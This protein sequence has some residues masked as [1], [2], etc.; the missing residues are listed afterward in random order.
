MVAAKAQK[1]GCR[2][3]GGKNYIRKVQDNQVGLRLNG[4][5]QLLCVEDVNLLVGNIDN[6]RKNTETLIDASKEAGL[7]LLHCHQIAEQNMAQFKYLGTTV[8]NQNLIQEEI[9]MRLNSGDACYHS[10]QNI[11]CSCLLSKNVK[12][13]L[14]ESVILPLVLYGCET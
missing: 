5:Y 14:Y 4:I 10:L 13:K 2:A 12:I 3:T 9:K 8:T 11:L 1:F 6:I 7:E